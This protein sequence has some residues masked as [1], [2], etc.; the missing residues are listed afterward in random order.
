MRRGRFPATTQRIACNAERVERAGSRA[1]AWHDAAVERVAHEVERRGG[2]EGRETKRQNAAENRE[3][4]HQTCADKLAYAALS[5]KRILMKR[6]QGN[7]CNK[8]RQLT[9]GSN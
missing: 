5:W 7:P 9:S 1:K 2:A 8:P 4:N 3:T 6:M